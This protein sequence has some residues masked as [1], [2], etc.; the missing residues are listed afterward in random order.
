MKRS[1][2]IVLGACAGLPAV[3]GA[4]VGVAWWRISNPATDVHELPSRLISI[5]SEQGEDLLRAATAVADYDVLRERFQTQEKA[6]WCGVA[7]S[8][9]VIGAIEGRDV[10]QD[11]FFDARTAEVRSFLRVS[12]T[13]MPLDDLGRLLEAHGLVADVHHAQ[14]TDLAT[15]RDRAVENLRRP[16]DFVLVNYQRAA[17]DQGSTGHISPLAAWEPISD[18]F[19]VLDV[20]TYE[21]P[22]VWVRAEDLFAAMDTI[23]SETDRSRGF[24]LVSPSR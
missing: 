12:F 23:D 6:T 9:M 20:A 7:S 5:H 8:A 11:A 21:W 22:P 18:R 19:L 14:D 16:G 17:L 24:V 13:G 1:T 3:V 15:F 2:A 10:S 4:I